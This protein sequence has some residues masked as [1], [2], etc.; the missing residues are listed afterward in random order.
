MRKLV[1]IDTIKENSSNPRFIKDDKYKKLLKSLKE[2]PQMLE[3]RPIVVDEIFF[4][5]RSKNGKVKRFRECEN[6]GEYFFA[7]KYSKDRIPKYCSSQCFGKTLEMI[8]NC[9]HCGERIINVHSVSLKNRIYCSVECS[10]K[11]RKNIPLSDDWK[12]ALSNGRKSSLKCRGENLYNWKGGKETF[13]IRSKEYFYKRK[14]NLKKDM[15]IS[16]LNRLE[17]MQN[18]KCF[19]CFRDISE[20]KAVEHLTPVSKGGDNDFFNLVYSCKSCN[21]EKKQCTL[22]EF[23]IK[24]RV[25]FIDR[26]ER[27]FT[28]CL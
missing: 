11:S 4:G 2:F 1:S 22:E 9:K 16:F 17:K 23:S 6:C 3:K 18:G 13:R 28:S 26:W 7:K 8:K 15:P 19:Y 25:N 21:S 24:K 20:Y 14:N 10:S 27:L 5:L 12:E